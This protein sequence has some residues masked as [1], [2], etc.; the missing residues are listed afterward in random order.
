MQADNGYICKY[1]MSYK[2]CGIILLIIKEFSAFSCFSSSCQ[3]SMFVNI[4]TCFA[5]NEAIL[6]IAKFPFHS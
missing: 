3:Y 4:Y 1:I 2:W 6:L 5:L